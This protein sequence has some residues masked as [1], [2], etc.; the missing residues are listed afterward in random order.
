[1]PAKS[2]AEIVSLTANQWERL[3][4]ESMT[5]TIVSLPD[6]HTCNLVI[7]SMFIRSQRLSG[8]SRGWSS[9]YGLLFD[10]FVRWQTWQPLTN[11]STS[12]C[13][14]GQKNRD[15]RIFDVRTTP[16]WPA[17]GESWASSRSRCLVT[18]LSGMQ[19]VL[20]AL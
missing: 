12:L 16:K 2:S 17:V 7:K 8:I 15:A 19:S 3:V 1:M 5:V 14:R 18:A 11:F 4:K 20:L 13:W 10:G 9:P 6:V